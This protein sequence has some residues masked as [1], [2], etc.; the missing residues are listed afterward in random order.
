[1]LDTSQVKKIKSKNISKTLSSASDVL[2]ESNKIY[3]AQ[4]TMHHF[5]SQ[6]SIVQSSS[7]IEFNLRGIYSGV[8]A[9]MRN[10]STCVIGELC[11]TML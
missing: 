7:L 10:I 4:I 8:H 11:T 6:P 3:Y 9:R 5:A 2:L 1:M